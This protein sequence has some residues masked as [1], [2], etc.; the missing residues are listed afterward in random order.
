MGSWEYVLWLSEIYIEKDSGKFC[1]DVGVSYTVSIPATPQETVSVSVSIIIYLCID[2]LN[3]IKKTTKNLPL[4]PLSLFVFCDINSLLI[5]FVS[6][7]VY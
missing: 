2:F 1:N 3:L 5:C 6:V 7:W 4:F